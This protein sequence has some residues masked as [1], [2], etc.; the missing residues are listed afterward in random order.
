MSYPI[1]EIEGIGPANGA[2]LKAAGITDTDALL[3]H[4]C[5]KKGRD[6][7][8]EKA[9]IGASSLLK[10]ANMA[11]MMRLKGVGRQYSELLEASGVDTI[12]ELRTRRADNLTAKM[13][14]V[15]A[16]K[17]L[18]KSTPSESMVT[19]WIEAAKTMEPLITH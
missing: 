2:K 10:W 8:A 11:D 13:S 5:D 6:A 3:K 16:A 7:M 18:A 19:E 15:N 12:K 9:G 4:C 17:K 14:E 1:E